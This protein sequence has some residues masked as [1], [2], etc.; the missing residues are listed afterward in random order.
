MS[1]LDRTTPVI[2]VT[3][4]HALSRLALMALANNFDV[5]PE[6]SEKLENTWVLADEQV[7][8]HTVRLGSAVSYEVDGHHR[9][10]T[11]VLPDEVDADKGHLSVLTPIG[12]ALMGL[13][14][15]QQGKWQSRDGRSHQLTVA[16][17]SRASK[18][19]LVAVAF[20]SGI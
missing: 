9:E 6:L 17:V 2:G 19:P 10:V 5:G 16:S 13:K 1:S 18:G 14:P 8:P 11:L 3:D 12:V 15:G 7:S 20:G 4:F